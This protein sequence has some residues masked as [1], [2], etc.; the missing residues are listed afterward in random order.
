LQAGGTRDGYAH[1][2]LSRVLRAS[3]CL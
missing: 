3:G 2:N 1:A